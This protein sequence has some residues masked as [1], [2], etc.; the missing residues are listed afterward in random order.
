MKAIIANKLYVP[1][2]NHEPM[3]RSE[4]FRDLEPGRYMICVYYMIKV[5]RIK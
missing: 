1:T 3:Y 5:K 2:Q 4:F